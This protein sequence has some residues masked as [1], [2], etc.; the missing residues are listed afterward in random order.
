MTMAGMNAAHAIDATRCPLCGAGN[1]CA[2]EMAH[3]TGQPQPPCW[4]M[5]RPVLDASAMQALQ[6]RIP[7]KA[8]GLAC[9]C[10]ACMVQLLEEQA[11]EHSA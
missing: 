1:R 4:C 10:A 6:E 8:R 3:A 9:V 5:D 2:V 7:E 11:R